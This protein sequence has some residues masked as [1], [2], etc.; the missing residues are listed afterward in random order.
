[1][2]GIFFMINYLFRRGET[3]PDMARTTHHQV[4]KIKTGKITEL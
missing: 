1:M 3:F 2:N 4:Q